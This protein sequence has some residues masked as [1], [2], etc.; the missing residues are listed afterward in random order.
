MSTQRLSFETR[1]ALLLAMTC[2]ER[3]LRGDADPEAHGLLERARFDLAQRWPEAAH[4]AL[5]RARKLLA[6]EMPSV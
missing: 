2:I 4:D 6:G 3:L 1:T 5:E